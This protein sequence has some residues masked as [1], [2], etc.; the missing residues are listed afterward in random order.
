MLNIS[1]QNIC[2]CIQEDLFNPNTLNEKKLTSQGETLLDEE[3]NGTTTLVGSFAFLIW[4]L[5][6][7]PIKNHTVLD[8]QLLVKKPALMAVDV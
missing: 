6:G 2:I 3:R 7:W 4:V 1:E 8:L 5:K